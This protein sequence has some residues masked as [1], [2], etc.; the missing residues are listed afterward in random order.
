MKT[1]E[2]T[3]IAAKEDKDLALPR[4]AGGLGIRGLEEEDA[5][6]LPIPFVRVVQGQSKDVKT[7]DG[8]EALEGS[9]FFGDTR[10]SFKDLTFCILKSKVVVTEMDD[11]ANPGKKKMVTQRKILGITMD[12][13]KLFMLTISVTS[14]A[15]YGRLIAEMKQNKV[16]N[17]WDRMV[18]AT[19][20]KQENDKGKF[21]VVNFALGEA[22][23]AEDTIELGF[24]FEQYKKVLEK[25]EEDV[26]NSEGKALPLQ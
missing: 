2:K 1:D 8:T 15:S 4:V 3:A 21:F 9:F 17:V 7:K 24:E 19:T 25:K 20:E 13:K 26:V 14:F 10:E 6:I 11:I 12:T 23:T 16:V 5:S 18:T 22:L